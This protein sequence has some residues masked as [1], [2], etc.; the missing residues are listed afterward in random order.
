MPL[1]AYD[2]VE[3]RNNYSVLLYSESSTKLLFFRCWNV[4]CCSC[5]LSVVAVV[6]RGPVVLRTYGTQSISE[7]NNTCE[8]DMTIHTRNTPWPGEI[9]SPESRIAQHLS[10]LSPS[11]T[12]H[13]HACPFLRAERGEHAPPDSILQNPPT[14]SLC[15]QKTLV[16]K[17]QQN[18][19]APTCMYIE[20]KIMASSYYR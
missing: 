18:N 14:K 3:P 5:C 12:Y 13:M 4:G 15:S 20:A 11:I 16:Q 7:S 9:T 19:C 2:R 17:M 1:E 8:Y 10:A 6:T